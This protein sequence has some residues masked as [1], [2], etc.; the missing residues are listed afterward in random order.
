MHTYRRKTILVLVALL[1]VFL[2]VLLIGYFNLKRNTATIGIAGLGPELDNM[3][4]MALS[5]IAIARVVYE[6]AA[7]ENHHEY[8]QRLHR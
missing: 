7:I 6:L 2:A 5:V 1:F 4:L 8:E 3:L